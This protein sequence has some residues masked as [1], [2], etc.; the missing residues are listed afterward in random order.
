MVS[1]IANQVLLVLQIMEIALLLLASNLKSLLLT[2]AAISKAM[3]LQLRLRSNNCSS[4]RCLNAKCYR[5]S[6]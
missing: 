5:F 1:V 3:M 6:F 2:N 4:T